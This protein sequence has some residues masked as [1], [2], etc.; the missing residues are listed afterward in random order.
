LSCADLETELGL[1]G[2]AVAQL[3]KEEEAEEKADK[4]TRDLERKNSF[5]RIRS[6]GVRDTF[7]MSCFA[8]Y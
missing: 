3:Q 7:N 4:V 6:C 1:S 8:E 5:C 2:E